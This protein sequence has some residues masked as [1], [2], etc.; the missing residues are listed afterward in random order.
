MRFCRAKTHALADRLGDLVAVAHRVKKRRSRS[1]RHVHG[2]V[3]DVG[4]GAGRLERGLADVGGEDLEGHAA[5]DARAVA[6]SSAMA[7][8]YTSSP[9]EQPGHPDA[10]GRAPPG[11]PLSEPGKTSR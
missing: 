9:V 6:S 3:L 4:A 7:R 10:E 5:C 11:A 2:D 8:E 1:G